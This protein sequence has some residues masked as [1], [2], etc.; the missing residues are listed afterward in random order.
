MSKQPQD[1]D[2]RQAP[3][4]APQDAAEQASEASQAESG[5]GRSG[6][7]RR[8]GGQGNSSRAGGTA[9]GQAAKASEAA[10]TRT[11]SSTAGAAT[12]D[13]PAATKAGAT[14]GGADK[15]SA[16]GKAASGKASSG[17]QGGTPPGASQRA[18]GKAGPIALVL[19]VVLALVG[20]VLGWIGWQ[21]LEAQRERLAGAEAELAE[22]RSLGDLEARLSEQ[23]EERRAALTGEVASLEGEFETYR[24]EV[25]EALDRVLAEL[26]QQQNAD[27]REWL[28]AEAA[29]LLRLANQRVQ[30]ERD[31]QGAAALL[32][33]ADARLR[34][35]DNPA[36]LPV[37]RALAA[38][39]A[40]LD[41]VPRVDRTGL[42]LA[43]NAQQEQLATLPL[44]QDVEALALE[45]GNG[46]APSGGWREQLGRFAGELRSLVT[47]RQH[48]EALEALIA[49][50]QE[51]YLRQNV[52]LLIEQ[53]QLALLKEEA[54]LYRASLD[55]AIALVE[56]YYAT[57][58]E[59][60][61]ASLARLAELRE[62]AVRPELPDISA[63]QQALNRFI[64]SRF[65][66]AEEADES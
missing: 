30:L 36:L 31:P 5:K 60:V 55:E 3:G 23:A 48:D 6:G 63:S 64:D 49:P 61:Q 17:G 13:K 9:Q 50:D 62:Q 47:V 32:R 43:L 51:A 33:T 44:S 11:D 2:E 66:G 16:G 38:E 45:I 29:Y 41:A 20:L 58:R 4:A 27:E 54:T 37:R 40:A 8:R 14:K 7:R 59:A 53:A 25:N 52:R 1:Q 42:Y 15:P 24:G 19:V 35:A 18:G 12:P 46:E 39:L 10:D 26:A 22:L 34:E 65:G 57:D 28:H 21:T 56:D